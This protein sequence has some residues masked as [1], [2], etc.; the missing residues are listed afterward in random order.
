VATWK[1]WSRGRIKE[2]IATNP[3]WRRKRSLGGFGGVISL[4]RG[5]GPTV[6]TGV[7]ENSVRKGSARGAKGDS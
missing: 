4:K 1:N 7:K 5:F 2:G 6:H 3:A